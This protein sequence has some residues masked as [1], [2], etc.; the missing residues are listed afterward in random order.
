MNKTYAGR[1]TGLLATLLIL[2]GCS[3]AP[4]YEVPDMQLPAEW[5]EA[6]VTGADSAWKTAEPAETAARGEWWKV[7]GDSRLDALEAE[8][9]M[10]NQNLRAAAARL[11]QSRSLLSTAKADRMPQVNAGF[12]PTRQRPSP[13][14]QGLPSD[15]D[16]GFSTLWRAQ[17]TV[18]YEADLFGRVAANVEAAR[19]DAA[20][21]EALFRSLQLALQADVA[22]AWFQLRELDAEQALFA[23]TLELRG[24]S[25]KL[26]QQRFAAGDVSELDLARAQTEHAVAQSQAQGVTLQRATTEHAIALLL[27]KTPAE[28]DLPAQPLERMS[29]RLPA[30]LPSS[31]LERRPD[32]AAA[33]R[34]MAA[35][36][37]R[38]GV[39]RSA[40]FPSLVI[41][42]NAGYESAGLGD[43][44]NWTSRSFLL[45]PLAGTMLN[46]PIFDGGRRSAAL[47]RAWATHEEQVANYRQS[48]LNAFREVEDGLAG[49]RLIDSRIQAQ[50]EAVR[51]SRR[52][53]TLAHTQYREGYT[54]S[55]EALDAD[56]SL[57][58][59]QRLAVQL[60]GARVRTAVNLIRAL[61]GG[62]QGEKDSKG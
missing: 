47:D 25:L 51:A 15:A 33:E 1:A 40:F 42:G 46:L 17:G 20:Q 34:A 35:A 10:A 43:L 6:P 23:R 59:Q 39:A 48:V 14:S 8:A 41:T 24:Q 13:V 2:A 11:Q 4:H 3:L 62:W 18:S 45:G 49:L 29:L 44:F 7:F 55:L 12:G 60:D 27:G 32:I 22:N 53:L 31:L 26:A 28:L 38:I 54:S 61:G 37:A 9:M 50:D 56:R 16:T 36:N 52:A 58:E 21:N 5:K 57:L 19:A 30:G